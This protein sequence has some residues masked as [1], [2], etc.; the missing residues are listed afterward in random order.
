MRV[1]KQLSKVSRPFVAASRMLASSPTPSKCTGL[2]WEEDEEEE[3][4]AAMNLRKDHASEDP[5]AAA[6]AGQ[7]EAGQPAPQLYTV[8]AE[9]QKGVA[10]GQKMGSD[11]VYVMPGAQAAAGGAQAAAAAGAATPQVQQQKAKKKKEKEFKF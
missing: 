3:E 1:G 2:R 7:R 4:E 5:S 11:K 9:Q 8:L 10:A 6:A